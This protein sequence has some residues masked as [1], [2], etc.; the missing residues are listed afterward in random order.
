MQTRRKSIYFTYRK[1]HK[2]VEN[3]N[4]TFCPHFKYLGSWISFSLRENHEVD[5]CIASTNTSMGEMASFLDDN[6]VDVYYKYLIFRAIP[7]NFPLWGCESWSLRQ[8]L[9]DA[10]KVFL[11]QS[12]RRILR[13]QVRHVIYHRIKNEH[14]CEMF[15]NIPT[16]RNRVAFFQ[17][18]YIG[19]IIRRESTRIPTRLL[20]AW[21]DH[22]CK[23]GRPILTNKQCI[24]RNIQL[25]IPEVDNDVTLASWVF[26]ALDASFW[27]NLLIT[28]KHPGNDPPES[29]PN[30][31]FPQTNSPTNYNG[32]HP[33]PSASPLEST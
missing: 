14:V 17:L 28:L 21:C 26:H 7:C 23:V 2:G 25:I 6:H 5:K 15:L 12:V 32:S 3:G 29:P 24:V 31:Y 27:N 20:T 1:K 18:T 30:T 13:I 33:P 19:E 9:L 8:T 22:P 16:I 11:H 4:V 10:F